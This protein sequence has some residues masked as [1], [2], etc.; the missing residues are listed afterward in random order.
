MTPPD[1]RPP[2]DAAA[3]EEAATKA[4]VGQLT[5][6]QATAEK[7][8]GTVTALL[9][10]FSTV[11]VVTG[12]DALADVRWEWGRWLLVVLIAAAGLA[13]A[14]S[15]LAAALAAQGTLPRERRNWSGETLRALINED[16]PKAVKKL[17]TSRLAGLTS[18]ALMFVVG[19]ASLVAAAVPKAAAQ[20]PSVIVIDKQGV[21]RCGTMT[22]SADGSIAI[23][24]VATTQVRRMILVDNC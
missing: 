20:D 18:A 3:W 17:R 11:A 21:A 8:A 13:A 2:P 15:I 5:A 12:V 7:W 22:T 24:E 9:G 10:A 6:V 4:A 1:D 23:A 16:T 14:V 19:L